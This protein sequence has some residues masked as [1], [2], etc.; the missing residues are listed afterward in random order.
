MPAEDQSGDVEVLARQLVDEMR[1]QP[2]RLLGQ[3]RASVGKGQM[4][5]TPDSGTKVPTARHY[6]AVQVAGDIDLL[7]HWPDLS[8]SDLPAVDEGMG[9]WWTPDD[10]AGEDY[11]EAMRR[12]QALLAQD[13]W[14]VGHRE[15]TGP[16]ALYTWVDLTEEEEEQ[17]ERRERRL[18]DEVSAQRVRIEPIVTGIAD[19]TRA[20]FD[21]EL[22]ARLA[23]AIEVRRRR[24]AARKAVA[25]ELTWPD[26]WK[27]DAPQLQRSQPDD[28]PPE[29]SVSDADVHLDVGARLASVSFAD[30]LR[31]IRVWADAVE[32][33]PEAYRYLDEDRVSDLLIAALT[34]AVPGAHREVYSR[35]GRS[36]IFIRA[37]ALSAGAAP[38]KIFIC[39]CKWWRGAQHA[40]H[41]LDQ[42]FGY[43]ETKDT[44]AVLIFFVRLADVTVAIREAFAAFTA[45]PYY[46]GEQ[47]PPVD[48]WPVLRFRLGPRVVDVCVAYVDFP[49]TRRNPSREKRAGRREPG[50][51]AGTAGHSGTVPG[52]LR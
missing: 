38:A 1:L 5:P 4:R 35:G 22:P 50:P 47:D 24:V 6:V 42:L 28:V 33:H 3:E 52:R 10:A 23:E 17:V 7:E 34:A 43:L 20:Y 51:A 9:D 36:D 48:G 18:A 37:D 2:P 15:D 16:R 8:G 11:V 14:F 41:A 12:H 49:P 19:Q 31:T 30:V 40:L 26:G 13:L 46:D 25:D 44:A 32:R 27:Y 45:R 39:E 21:S 29:H